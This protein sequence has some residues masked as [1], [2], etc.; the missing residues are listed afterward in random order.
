M[1]RSHAPAPLLNGHWKRDSTLGGR[2]LITP[3]DASFGATYEPP[4]L[5]DSCQ[6][7]HD[8]DG[9][10]SKL[11]DV[12]LPFMLRWPLLHTIMSEKDSR[13]IFYFM[14]LNFCFMAVQAFY[15]YVTESLG[16]LSDSI[17]MFFDCVALAVGLFAAVASR[18]PAN[19]RF[20][21]G[22][23]KIETLSGFANGLFLVLISVEIMFEAFERIV[24]G[25]ETKRLA[26]LF[27][28]STLGLLVNLVGMLAF[29]HHHHGH[30]HGHGH[31]HDHQSHQ[32]EG[33]GHTHGCRA[34]SS[35][36]PVSVGQHHD[37][38]HHNHE[39][40]DHGHGS[41]DGGHSKA[42][43]MHH[44]HAH[45]HANENMHGIYL[46]VLADTLGS[47]AVIVSTILT[48]IWGWPGWDPLA[49]FLI[50][51]LILLSAIPLVKSSAAKLLLTVP[52]DVEYNLRETLSGISGLKGVAGYTVPK[53]WLDDR[54]D[55]A[56]DGRSRL[57]G[58]MHVVVSRG[59]DLEDVQDRVRNYLLQ[60]DMDITVQVERDGDTGCWCAA[61]AGRS[62]L[63]HK[64]S[65]SEM[66]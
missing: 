44:H 24:E 26:E 17:H 2:P 53:F 47:A 12:L 59:S 55:R 50:A 31:C 3:T 30:G 46:H 34:H 22:F 42:R 18:W 16:L 13:R 29:G 10:R 37:Y 56:A 66:Q 15:G 54:N 41:R 61:G 9:G 1:A 21:Y 35:H 33:N 62:S 36:A 40:H 25:R 65:P 11:T 14:S 32:S 45:G 64:P 27:V 49:S 51:I 7:R 58:A 20:P 52:D 60:R 19:E 48:K 39:H 38:V 5:Y 23:G 28:V 63:S 8:S 6:N 57:V 43:I 4:V